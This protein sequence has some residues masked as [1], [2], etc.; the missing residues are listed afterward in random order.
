MNALAAT[1]PPLSVVV[2]DDTADL[3]DL[4]KIA[5]TRGGFEVVGEA[6]DGQEGID[7]V[8]RLVPD[9]VLLDL[10]MP[11][12]DGI[13]ALP[14]IRRL[15]P[16]G[17][18]VVLSGFGAQHMSERAVNAGADGYVQKGA[19]LNTIL[20]YVRE[21]C[22]GSHI[23]RRSLSVVSADAP[24][25]GSTS[26]HADKVD[27]VDKVDTV[28]K[29]PP[30]AAGRSGDTESSAAAD[31]TTPP[32]EVSVPSAESTTSTPRAPERTRGGG[33]GAG[34]ANVSAWEA[35]RV[36]PYGVI[37]L[38]DEPL[39]RIVHANP[40]GAR[41]LGTDK[42]GTP[43]AMVAS[44]LAALVSYHRLDSDASFE[45]EVDG[46]RVRASLRR[47]GWSILVFLDSAA[48]DVG[49]LRRAIATTAHEVRGPVAVLCGIAETLAWDGN[50]MDDAMH[51]R[52]LTSVARQARILDQITADLLTAA[53]IQRGT[54]R[55]DLQVVE[56]R[57]IVQGIVETRFDVDVAYEDDRAVRADPLRLEQMITNLLSNAHKYGEAPFLVRVRPCTERDDLVCI[58]VVDHGEGVPV[59]F[60]DHLFRE[61]ARAHGA[62]ATG[63]GLG[64]YVV[65]TLAQAQQG[66]VSYTPGAERGSIFTI[67]LQADTP[68]EVG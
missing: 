28:A 52:L 10:A 55:V 3:R 45:A 13:E 12:M 54:L 16:K 21:V 2:I 24:H 62:V 34:P 15:T 51:D 20:D 65:R 67:R 61:F 36:A 31:S 19:P 66:E 11:V 43:L 53:Q 46:G 44:E 6:G 59:E 33:S 48:E 27:K 8:R 32:T 49:L 40:L 17:K 64:L 60:R 9:V 23:L 41:L 14:Q 68:L 7:T 38:A 25:N 1:T 18:I 39:F 26:L 50:Q 4:L 47:T 35:L 37:E 22:S 57:T 63:T 42:A 30:P 29:H 5:L 56:P 58:D